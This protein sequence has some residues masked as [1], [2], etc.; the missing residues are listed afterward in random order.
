MRSI[1]VFAKNMGDPYYERWGLFYGMERNGTKSWTK[2][3]N[4]TLSQNEACSLPLL[5]LP[6]QVIDGPPAGD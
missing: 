5:K 2:L 1:R 4:G 6:F 3:R